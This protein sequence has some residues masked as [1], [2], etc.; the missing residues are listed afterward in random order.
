MERE[1]YA[2]S[3]SSSANWSSNNGVTRNG[4]DAS[5]NPLNATPKAPNFPARSSP[6][7]GSMV[8]YS[9]TRAVAD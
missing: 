9:D 4:K 8:Y 3:G 5:N 2:V 7:S 6:S 1:D